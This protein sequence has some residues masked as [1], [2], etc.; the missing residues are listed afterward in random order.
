VAIIFLDRDQKLREAAVVDKRQ[1]AHFYD[2]AISNLSRANSFESRPYSPSGGANQPGRYDYLAVGLQQFVAAVRDSVGES[3]Q[4]FGM[5]MDHFG[6]LAQSENDLEQ[7]G[8]MVTGLQQFC[9]ALKNH[10]AKP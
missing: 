5:A 6:R 2:L 10:F 1:L 9:A 3:D 7:F 4:L 8:H